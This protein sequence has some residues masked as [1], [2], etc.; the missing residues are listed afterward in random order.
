MG[1]GWW[2]DTSCFVQS[3]GSEPMKTVKALGVLGVAG[4][5]ATAPALG[6]APGLAPGAA[7]PVMVMRG[8]FLG[9]KTSSCQGIW[10]GTTVRMGR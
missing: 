6:A 7:G 8:R 10:M 4:G 1:G 5:E 2:E 9:T 3:G